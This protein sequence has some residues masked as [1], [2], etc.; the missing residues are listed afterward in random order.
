[1]A[2][3]EARARRAETFWKSR[4]SWNIQ[5]RFSR[6]AGCLDVRQ[7]ENL[8]W[9]TTVYPKQE[10]IEICIQA[11]RQA[12][13]RRCLER[14][15]GSDLGILCS[16]KTCA[17]QQKLKKNWN[18]SLMQERTM[19]ETRKKPTYRIKKMKMKIKPMTLQKKQQRRKTTKNIHL[20]FVRRS[21]QALTSV[22]CVT[23]FF[24]LFVEVTVKTVGVLDWE[25]LTT[26][27]RKNRIKIEQEGA[28]SAQEQ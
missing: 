9:R 7:H 20:W 13:T 27:V 4:I 14:R 2:R 10:K 15:R 5:P 28:K 12:L 22:Q 24:M 17:L 18:S 1:M 8:V 23:S 21:H 3:N 16:L 11:S 19:V 6:Y 25:S 26:S